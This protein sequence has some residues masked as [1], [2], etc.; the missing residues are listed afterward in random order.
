M[1]AAKF[2][3]PLAAFL[4]VIWFFTNALINAGK[5]NSTEMVVVGV[6]PGNAPAKMD[7]SAD[8][9]DKQLLDAYGY[10]D[11]SSEIDDPTLR[12]LDR[13]DELLERIN[14]KL[15]RLLEKRTEINEQASRIEELIKERLPAKE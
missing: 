5:S 12:K 1:K 13:I 9:S 10:I 15:D 6:V 7:E 4:F 8:N 11:F 14:E 2:L 3:L